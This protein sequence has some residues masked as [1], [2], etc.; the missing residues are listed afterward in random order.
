MTILNSGFVGVNNTLPAYTLDI[1]GNINFTGNVTRNG[2]VWPFPILSNTTSS[3]LYV[4]GKHHN[5]VEDISIKG[6][7]YNSDSASCFVR[8]AGINSS[9]TNDLSGT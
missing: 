9:T 6:S 8:M 7:F 2:S 1:G 4:G 5:A 3:L